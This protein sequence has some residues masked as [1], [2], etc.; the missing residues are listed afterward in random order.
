[1]NRFLRTVLSTVLG[2]GHAFAEPE[3]YV[4]PLRVSSEGQK[5]E[6]PYM[7]EARA[8]SIAA[9]GSRYV[10]SPAYKCRA[11]TYESFLQQPPFVLNEWL[12]K[13]ASPPQP[14][15]SSRLLRVLKLKS[16]G[17]GD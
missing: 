7:A 8:R 10:L 6:P 12:R 16:E 9:L 5:E 14:Q 17:H 11:V 13:R 15:K 4:N 1:M 3:V 2:S